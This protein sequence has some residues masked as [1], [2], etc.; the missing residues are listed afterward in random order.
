MAITRTVSP[1]INRCQLTCQDRLPID[2]E[3]AR[4]QHRRYEDCLTALGCAVLRLPAE[5]TLPDSV[6]VEDAAIVLDE[7]AVITRPGAE[8]RRP[9][10]PSIARAL[11]PYRPLAYIEEPGVLDGGDVLR[12]GRKLFVGLSLRSN[13]AAIEQ[14]RSRLH[15]FG[16]TVAGVQVKGCLHLKSAVTRVGGEVL[17]I[18]RD[19]VDG[20]VF[21]SMNL[22]EVDAN[23]PFAANA[24]M[25]GGVVIFPSA[26]PATRKRLEALGI[27]VCPVDVSELA[28]AEGGVTCCSLIF[29]RE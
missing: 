15:G 8:S 27:R 17:L 24:L 25:I 12:V 5:P 22:L 19:W 21:A 7:L 6:F 1:E 14:L 2:L 11:R 10:I 29:S 16:Y 3:L 28:K 9:E 18:N 26:F 20:G 4:R 13:Q 23:E